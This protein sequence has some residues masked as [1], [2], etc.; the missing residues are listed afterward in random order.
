MGA[1]RQRNGRYRRSLRDRRVALLALVAVLSASSA[2]SSLRSADEAEDPPDRYPV[3]VLNDN[4]LNVRV[5][6]VYRTGTR[7]H[8]GTALSF[9]E[10]RVRPSADVLLRDE[11]FVELDLVGGATYRVP[12]P[13]DFPENAVGLDVYVRPVLEQSYVSVR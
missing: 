13:V 11:F 9:V 5:D 4:F 8:L 3:R 2:C 7:T 6:L 10:T 1:S 12:D